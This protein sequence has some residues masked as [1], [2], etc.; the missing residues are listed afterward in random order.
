MMRR[1][2]VTGGSGFVGANVARR[3][4]CDGHQVHLI[5]RP[6][7]R[8]WRIEDIL[9]D[10]HLHKAHL[11]DGEC[12][13]RVCKEIRPDWIFHLAT[14]G[15]YSYQNDL[16]AIV[17]TNVMGTINLVEACIGCGFEAFVNTG[18]S[19]E[20]GFKSSAP[21]ENT[22]LEP[23]SYYA[24][25]K[26][27]ATLFCRYTAQ[28]HGLH[29][30]TLRLY[31][32]Y[33]PFEEPTRLIPTL[34]RAG[35]NDRSLP[36]LAN[37]ATARDY[38]YVDDAVQAYMLAAGT[39]GQDLGVIYNIGS[40]IQTRLCE[41]VDIVRQVLGILAE[42]A[43]NSMESRH[44]D[45]NVWVANPGLVHERLGWKT[46]YDFERGFRATVEWL[47][48]N[49]GVANVYGLKFLSNWPGDSA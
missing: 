7:A 2:L 23:N 48:E 19:S 6:T 14:Y 18:S 42:P 15:A 16:H 25:T 26:A 12:I 10:T 29:I 27:S 33:G 37:P 46:K 30:P 5:V 13:R 47:R 20:Y 1:C 17:H 4:L 28:K 8:L 21:A 3:L 22:W 31:S 36:P 39:H 34:V 32:I 40:G 44:W 9:E 45:T 49:T 43:W 35:L 38:V 41:V 24:V 11:E